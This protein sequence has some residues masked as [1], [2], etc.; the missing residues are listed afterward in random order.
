MLVR[1][2]QHLSPGEAAPLLALYLDDPEAS[3]RASACTAIGTTRAPVSLP[4]VAAALSDRSEAVR[5]ACAAA[6]GALGD[7]ASVDGLREGAADRAP[8]VRASAARAMGRI[9]SPE[10]V[11]SLLVALQDPH[12]DVVV[13]ALAGFA[14]A[15]DPSAVYAVLERVDDPSTAVALAAVQCSLRSMR[16]RAFPARPH[17]RTGAPEAAAAAFDALSAM[18]APEGLPAAIAELLSPRA[19]QSLTAASRL[20]AALAD[21]GALE[22]VAPLL[23]S[24][25]ERLFGYMEAVGAAGWA[26]LDDAWWAA[27]EDASIQLARLWLRSGDPSAVA[28]VVVAFGTEDADALYALLRQSPSADAVRSGDRA[29]RSRGHGAAVKLVRMGVRG[30]RSAVHRA[31]AERGTRL[32]RRGASRGR[33]GPRHGREPLALAPLWRAM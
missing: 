4:H 15:G 16:P 12:R 8:S 7:E 31:T 10:A 29:A 21:P 27:P 13:A 9:G 14:A 28:A 23:R 20:L 11:A 32:A 6:L 2:L 24:H 5:R 30:R 19:Q 3:V 18:R 33:C 25:P 22:R 17:A 26:A 1:D